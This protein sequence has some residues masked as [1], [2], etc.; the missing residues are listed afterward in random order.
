MATILTGLA[1]GAS[2]VASGV[3]QPSVILG[4]LSLDNWHMIQAFLTATATSSIL[5]TL[6]QSLNYA[7]FKPRSYSPIGLFARY[8]GNILGGML[9]GHGMALS[10][11]CPGTVL[12]QV[13]LGIR[14]GY[15]ALA[16]AA[17]GGVVYSGFVKPY[18]AG[19]EKAPAPKGEKLGVHEVLGVSRTVGFVGLEALLIG[20]VGATVVFT[21]LGPEAKIH[22]VLGGVLIG[23]VTQGLSILSRK[24]LIGIST[25]FEEV[26]EWFWSLVRGEGWP[27][28]SSI[29]FSAAVVAGSWLMARF[30]PELGE[31]V[32]VEVAPASAALGGALMVIGSRI[33]GGCTS[34]HGVSGM[35]L[36]SVSSA[37]TIGV[38][39]AWGCVAVKFLL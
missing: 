1:F 33:A 30:V 8:D 3:Y 36:L 19:R 28:Y 20:V 37:V 9:L 29:V 7:T 26:G 4:Q 25:S 10:G 27:K 22:P 35:S 31:V 6:A 11:A 21:S 16:G 13:A 17:A 32:G 18:L 39:V 23:G 38:A 15:F 24:S 5:V 12:S 2:L 14:S 34:G